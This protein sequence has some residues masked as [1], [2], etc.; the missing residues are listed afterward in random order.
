M[1]T[2]KVGVRERKE[3]RKWVAPTCL[4]DHAGL[5]INSHIRSTRHTKSARRGG[6]RHLQQSTACCA[7]DNFALIEANVSIHHHVHATVASL[8]RTE[9]FVRRHTPSITAAPTNVS[10]HVWPTCSP[11]DDGLMSAT[12]KCND[13]WRKQVFVY[14]QS[15]PASQLGRDD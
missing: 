10:I 1:A 6:L 7:A 14:N 12:E 9:S 13:G 8:Q 2:A 5:S 11:V 15:Q 3:L 4:I